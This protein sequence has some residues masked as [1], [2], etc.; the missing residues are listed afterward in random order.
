MLRLG[1]PHLPEK[2]V[3]DECSMQWWVGLQTAVV[4][5]KM[6]ELVVLACH[7]NG[8]VELAMI[9]GHARS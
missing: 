8:L 2:L 3:G 7:Q 1:V 5:Q 4:V 9:V 6:T